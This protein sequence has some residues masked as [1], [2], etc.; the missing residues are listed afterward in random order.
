MNEI[1]SFDTIIRNVVGHLVTV[2]DSREGMVLSLPTM[3]PSGA[4]VCVNVAYDGQTCL[5]NDMGHG[6]HEAELAGVS[7]RLFRKVA[8][9]VSDEYGIQFDNFCFFAIQ[10]PIE[11]VEGAIRII[12][13]A[14]SKSVIASAAQMTEQR[15]RTSR[16][17]LIDRLIDV[18]GKQRVEQ[19]Y[20]ISGSSSHKW[21][22]AG[23]VTT[24]LGRAVFDVA[25]PS[26]TSVFGVHTKVS[27]VRRLSSPPKCVI[28]VERFDLFKPDYRNLLQQAA[29]MIEVSASREVYEKLASIAA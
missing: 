15:E 22:F 9:E 8:R 28:A 16:A 12:G 26:P 2:R 19:D 14:S 7:D 6:L 23:S 1:T 17:D 10:V 4:P 18:Y 13:S 21:V 3:Y 24:A 25:T 5:V 20:S 11:K 27:D 29:N